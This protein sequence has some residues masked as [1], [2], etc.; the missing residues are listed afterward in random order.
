MTS[1]T[2]KHRYFVWCP[3]SIA[4]E[5]KLVVIPRGDDLTFGLL[6]SR[7]HVI[8]ALHLGSTLEDRPVYTTSR[9]FE[10][11]PFPLGLTPA[12]TAHQRSEVL[13][14]GSVIPAQ[15]SDEKQPFRH[16]AKEFLATQNVANTPQT[17][18]TTPAPSSVRKRAM[19]IAAAARHLHT[20][21]ERWLN[22]PEWTE[23]VP[24]VVPLGMDHSPY[25]DR[26]LPKP[27][28][29]QD[30]AERTLTKLYNQRPEW[31]DGA[32]R[33][34]DQAVAAA[35]GWT[36]YSADMADDEILQRLLALNQERA[37]NT[38]S[39]DAGQS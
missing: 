27:G 17:P 9:C 32:H 13:A 34:L 14:D 16:I 31:L 11:F 39:V 12:D 7:I 10:T 6:S 18:V 30:L 24:E 4:P 33:A 19:A 15:L 8:W 38:P 23:R 26:I 28:H 25:P 36:D 21:R 29:A 1:E 20:L 2:S 37:S 3:T 35:Y 5:H 22:P